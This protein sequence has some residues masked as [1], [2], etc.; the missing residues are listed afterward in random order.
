MG[1]A[2]FVVYK[3]KRRRK[4]FDDE[5]EAQA[6]L[7]K[8]KEKYKDKEGLL[9][10]VVSISIP[11]SRNEA[12]LKP[13][14]KN[15]YWCPYCREWRKFGL[16]IDSGYVTCPLCSISIFD[17]HVRNENRLWGIGKN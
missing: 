15:I 7:E 11:F 6:F 17:F 13:K 8:I 1:W 5:K 2:V 3:G 9:L 10:G 14:G 16:S 12:K 4:N